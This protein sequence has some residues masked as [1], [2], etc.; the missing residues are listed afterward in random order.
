MAGVVG[1]L[2]VFAR[3]GEPILISGPTGAG[4]SRLARWCHENSGV[5]KE[6]FEI[7]DL[8]TVPE[9]LQMAELFGWKKGAFTGAVR[10]TPGLI[11]RAR[12]GTLFID[13]IDNLSPRA[14]AGLLHVFEERTYRVLGDS[15]SETQ[16][17]VR[18]IIGTNAN[19]QNSVRERRFREDLYYRINV[20]PVKLL[21]LCER[22]DEIA[23]WARYMAVRRHAARV[24]DGCVELSPRAEAR[25]VSER[26]PGNLRQLDNI[27][28]RAYAIALLAHGDVAP[29][30]MLLDD[31]HFD[32]ALA[33]EGTAQKRPL[34]EALLSAA[35]AFV[36]EA[37]RAMEMGKPLDLDLTE[38]F[39]GFVL[40]VA[41]EKFGGSREKALR[42]FGREKLISSRNHQKVFKR[43]LE[44]VE[45]LCSSIG[46][47][48]EPP[49]PGLTDST[50]GTDPSGS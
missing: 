32:R 14:Q 42:L 26:W 39:K 11:A 2:R 47:S 36:G 27:V 30:H 35:M 5:G 44:R 20:L 40:G 48:G 50:D 13:E 24:P 28:R 23:M 7:L 16:A 29:R 17:E 43:E 4:K 10:D 49:F 34:V 3:Q 8:T 15:G 45:S 12:G 22:A 41:A 1:L 25:L 37:E 9:E 46:A 38:S 6:P 19:L 18:F 31:E 33:Y 21:P